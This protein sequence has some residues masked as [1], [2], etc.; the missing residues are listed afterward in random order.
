MC[1]NVYGI[2]A[3]FQIQQPKGFYIMKKKYNHAVPLL[4]LGA[5][6]II[7]ILGARIE[8]HHEYYPHWQL[9]PEG[10]AED[11]P[12]GFEGLTF[13][14]RADERIIGN[15]V[16]DKGHE[17][18]EAW[19]RLTEDK[20]SG[21][22][23]AYVPAEMD[24]HLYLRMNSA[25]TLSVEEAADDSRNDS[26]K[27]ISGSFRSGD[28]LPAFAENVHYTFTILDADGNSAD[29]QD[30]VFL[31]TQNIPSM[32]IETA[33]GSM[34]AVNDDRH[35]ETSED[36]VYRIYQTDGTPDSSGTCSIKGR[37]NSTWS[38]KKKPYNLNMETE[39]ELL[40]MSS[41]R[42]FALIANF[43]DSSQVRQYYAFL[44]AERLG[45]AYTPQTRFVNLYINGRYQALYLL[46]QRLNVSGGTVKINN[47]QKANR[48][49]NPEQADADDLGETADSGTGSTEGASA[50]D[51]SDS[52]PSTADGAALPRKT[53]KSIVME[54][55]EDG[56]EALAYDWENDPEDISGGY[57]LE[58]DERYSKNDVWFS[59][60]THHIDIQSP[61]Q[62]SVSEYQYIADY[63][64]EAEKA[65]FADDWT[66]PDTGLTCFDYFD[67]DSWA[68][69]YLIQDFFVQSDDEFYS[70]FFYKKAGDPLL[71]CGPVWDFDLCLGNMNCGDY[72]KTSARTLWLRDGRKRWLHRMGQDPDFAA[73]VSKIYLEELEPV[74]RNILKNEYD[75]NRDLLEVDTKLHYLRWHKDLDYDER[76]GLVK[77]LLEERVQ[78]L[79]DYYSD[80]DSFHRLLF[81]FAWDDFSYYVRDGESM[82]FLPTWDYGEKQSSPQ[83][84][85]NGFITG[86]SDPAGNLLQPD[87]PIYEDREFDP[88]YIP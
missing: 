68:R 11:Y 24:D 26:K 23:Y 59:T 28:R 17:N 62:P 15:P 81:H 70:F 67:M 19:F 51:K 50:A 86:W 30:V 58:M 65:L 46:N 4:L 5:L 52:S 85:A 43:W 38:Q 9:D 1:F 60:D 71:Y 48:K 56:H 12:A 69:M 37:G 84:E 25:E 55:D 31:Y 83:R 42:K 82:G 64:R 13:S 49:A 34:E 57:L 45:L 18:E 16:P 35:H 47:L 33:S 61:S 22:W 20:D 53:L 6:S 77:T 63:V 27:K 72:Y 32:Y 76:T 74:I 7:F 87:E 36:A 41:C 14:G 2:N 54:T 44:A 29:S 10:R 79:H 40:G 39:N 21:T 78:F 73:L 80:P 75:Q 8:S 66:N 88:V 3:V